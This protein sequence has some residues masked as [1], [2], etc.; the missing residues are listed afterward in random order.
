MIHLGAANASDMQI[1]KK[2][3][4]LT[5]IGCMLLRMSLCSDLR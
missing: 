3:L 4:G 2:T 1:I 5:G